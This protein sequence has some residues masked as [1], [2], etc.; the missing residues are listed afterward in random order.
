[1]LFIMA[2]LLFFVTFPHAYLIFNLFKFELIVDSFLYL[3]IHLLLFDF[4]CFLLFIHFIL[5]VIPF[6]AS[7]LSLFMILCFFIY[8]LIIHNYLIII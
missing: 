5:L 3:F 4:E 6:I 7:R 8:Y 1:M 2:Y